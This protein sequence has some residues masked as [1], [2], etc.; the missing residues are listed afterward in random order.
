MNKQT[1]DELISRATQAKKNAYAPYSKFRVGAAILTDDGTI[2]DGSN[3]ENASYGL[4]ICA[5]RNAVFQAVHA[6]KRKI[7][8]VAV[9]S[10]EKTF[11]TP[12]GACRQVI[13]EFADPDT[14]IILITVDGK[15][16]VV[17]FGKIFPAPPALDKLKK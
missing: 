11:I 8:A 10:D 9:T 5:E 6:K 3:V 7:T 16:K 17:K 14:E 15:W 1:R 4:T 2:F 12:C 13:A